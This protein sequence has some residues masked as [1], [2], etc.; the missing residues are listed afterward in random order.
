MV[1]Y[2]DLESMITDGII[3]RIVQNLENSTNCI[4]L[5]NPKFI[6]Y[7]VGESLT[8]SYPVLDIFSNPRKSM[9]GGFIAAAFD[10]IFGILV[11]IT[12]KKIE[13]A[14]IDISVNYLRPIFIN[15]TLIVKAYLKSKGKIIVHLIGEA[16]DKEKNLIATA[17]TNIMLLEKNKY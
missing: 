15:D 1:R 9:Q 6:E 14:S 2:T 16:Y 5:M 17:S 12:T 7:I 13:M 8:Y 4:K 3:D 10:N 11:Y